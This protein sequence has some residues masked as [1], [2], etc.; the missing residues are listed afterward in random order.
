[1]Y[2]LPSWNLS[3]HNYFTGYFYLCTL[4][5][6]F[7]NCPFLFFHSNR[8]VGRVFLKLSPIFDKAAK[9]CFSKTFPHTGKEIESI[10]GVTLW[11]RVL[12]KLVD[13]ELVK[14]LSVL[15][16]TSRLITEES[17]LNPCYIFIAHSFMDHAVICSNT[18]RSGLLCTQHRKLV[19]CAEC[20]ICI[21]IHETPV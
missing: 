20:V 17:E 12:Q 19:H 3:P 13:P 6:S 18:W 16:E 4:V 5:V 1:M 15:C 7:C 8:N 10:R 9:G 14:K 21:W 2:F 11:N